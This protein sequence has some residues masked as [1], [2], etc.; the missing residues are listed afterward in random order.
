MPRYSQWRTYRRRY[1]SPAVRKFRK[2][3]GCLLRPRAIACRVALVADRALRP[4][5][6]PPRKREENELPE[7]AGSGSVAALAADP[8]EYQ[9]AAAHAPERSSVARAKSR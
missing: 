2:L 1:N 7:S 9:P 3:D 6:C 4:G 5:H 8:E